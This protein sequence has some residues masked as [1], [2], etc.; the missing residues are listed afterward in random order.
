M[1]T[2]EKVVDVR[3]TILAHL[4]KEDRRLT[5]LAKKTG[6][7]YSTL[8]TIFVQRIMKLSKDRLDTINFHLGTNF[9]K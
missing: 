6:Y 5:W 4:K 2:K 9:K 8:Y 3:D 7:K 1:A